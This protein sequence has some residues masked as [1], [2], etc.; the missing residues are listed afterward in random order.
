MAVKDDIKVG[1]IA[2]NFVVKVLSDGGIQADPNPEKKNRK[3]MQQWDLS[4]A[5]PNSLH[6]TH[7]FIE[8]K[9]DKMATKT[10]NLAIEYYNPK[11]A[12]YSGIMATRADLWA[13][14][15]TG[16]NNELQ[17]W[18][19]KA[20]KLKEYFKNEKC[21][22]DVACGGDNNS[23][24]K[25]YKKDVLLSAIFTRIDNIKPEELKKVIN[26]VLEKEAI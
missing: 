8:A 26:N 20:E 11:Q 2:E 22:R 1:K 24:M 10:G 23:S 6:Q 5:T 12:K 15:L 13:L 14:V 3:I 25:L 19:C 7:V 21:H 9:F 16:E 4:I 17:L 18:I